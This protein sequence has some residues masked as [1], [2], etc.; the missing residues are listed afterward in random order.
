M[1]SLLHLGMDRAVSVTIRE[2]KNAIAKNIKKNL[3]ARIILTEG[4]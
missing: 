4:K 1:C 2:K 3:D